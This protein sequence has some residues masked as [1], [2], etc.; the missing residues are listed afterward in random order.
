MPF[1]LLSHPGCADENNKYSCDALSNPID[2]MSCKF[3]FGNKTLCPT[4]NT[5]NH[6]EIELVFN[7]ST[8]IRIDS[9]SEINFLCGQS[10][11]PRHSGSWFIWNMAE[12]NSRHTQFVSRLCVA[13]IKTQTLCCDRIETH[14]RNSSGS[15]NFATSQSY[16]NSAKQYR[17]FIGSPLRPNRNW[18]LSASKS[19][20]KKSDS[21]AESTNSSP[22]QIFFPNA[23][24]FFQWWL[25][26]PTLN[27]LQRV[28]VWLTIFRP[29]NKMFYDA[30]SGAGITT[31]IPC[32]KSFYCICSS[33]CFQM[34]CSIYC[35]TK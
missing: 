27:N 17:H 22:N 8:G 15:F 35:Q 30:C 3:S 33:T 25:M 1:I 19:I 9:T 29:L 23:K 13:G 12:S 5:W 31:Q 6:C 4:K 7:F 32:R 11:V 18:W 10:F 20:Q 2:E 16:K 28:N 34:N 14:E 24:N 21:A 26:R